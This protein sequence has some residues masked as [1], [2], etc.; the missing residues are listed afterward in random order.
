MNGDPGC[1]VPSCPCS[2]L[3]LKAELAVLK[4]KYS[5][6]LKIYSAKSDKIPDSLQ[7]LAASQ[8]RLR[9]AG[10]RVSW[11]AR[12]SNISEETSSTVTCDWERLSSAG[13]TSVRFFFFEQPPK[14]RRPHE[15]GQRLSYAHALLQLFPLNSLQY[16]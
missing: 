7:H 2:I 4:D 11:L 6:E 8:G 15:A 1:I 14:V 10:K 3:Q 16:S 13:A 9:P 12:V 5:A